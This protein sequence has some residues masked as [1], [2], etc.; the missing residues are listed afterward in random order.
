MVVI[1]G[2][3]RFERRTSAKS[4]YICPY[5]LELD[6]QPQYAEDV[7]YPE[8]RFLTGIWN[9]ALRNPDKFAYAA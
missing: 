3:F 1:Q 5:L 6:C 8:R 2:S 7:A 4:D 9:M